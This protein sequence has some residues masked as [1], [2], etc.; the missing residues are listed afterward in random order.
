MPPAECDRAKEDR[1]KRRKEF[2]P[3]KDST[4]IRP[5][6]RLHRCVAERHIDFESNKPRPAAFDQAGMSVF[7]EGPGFS[8]LDLNAILNQK[9]EWIAVASFNAAELID[10]ADYNFELLHDPYA[11]ENGYQHD[12]H[13]IVVCK[14]NTTKGTKMQLASEWTIPPPPAQLKKKTP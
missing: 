9:P 7:V 10:N 14:K 6:H 11:D 8:P 1:E 4:P 13:A 12:N 2:G 3:D 5:E